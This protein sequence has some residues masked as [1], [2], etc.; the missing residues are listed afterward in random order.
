M[1][2]KDV[3]KR[4]VRVE[5]T[6]Y[7]CGVY[8]WLEMFERLPEDFIFI[9]PL[10]SKFASHEF[11]LNVEI[12]TNELLK[13]KTCDAPCETTSALLRRKISISQFIRCHMSFYFLFHLL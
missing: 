4:R 3:A 5:K 12:I 6:I 1:Y 11:K 13:T 10:N 2:E 9:S 8:D 7:I